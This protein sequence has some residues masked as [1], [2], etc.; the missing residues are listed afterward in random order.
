MGNRGSRTSD[1]LLYALE[2]LSH[3]DFKRFKDKLSHVDFNGRRNIPRGKLEKAD[4]IDTKNLLTKFYGT[5]AAVDVTIEVFTRV[6]LME[7]AARLQEERERALTC[8][9]AHGIT[10]AAADYRIRYMEHIVE[11]YRL[12]EDRNA[13]IG[14]TV[15]LQKRYTKLLIINKHRLVHELKHEV[16]S[17]GRKHITI[18][19][20]LANSMHYT[21]IEALFNSAK[22]GHRPQTV[23]LL[24]PAGIGKTM[25]ARKIMLDWASGGLYQGLFSY[26]FYI[27]CRE[28]NQVQSQKSVTD[29]ISATC[30]NWTV[31]K[32][33]LLAEPNTLLFIVDGFDELKFSLDLQENQF[34]SDPAK[35]DNVEVTLSNLFRRNIL[36]RCS[37]LITTRPTALARL[38]QY[39]LHPLCAEIMGFTEEDRWS[40]FKHFFE[41]NSYASRAFATVKDNDILYTMCFVPI[42]CWIVCTVIKQQIE[43]E[44]DI[45]SASKTT[46]SLYL[47]FLSTLLRDHSRV[48][49]PT[50]QISLKRL[51]SLALDGIMKQRIL[52]YEEDMMQYDLKVSDVQ[53]LF[54]NTTIFQQDIDCYTAY[55]FIHLSFQEFF[56]A[57]YYV[58]DVEMGSKDSPTGYQRDIKHLL[59][60]SSKS[61]GSHLMLTVRFLFGL[62]NKER[63]IHVEKTLGCK[64]S[65]K[66]RADLLAWIQ[67]PKQG[68]LAL[69][70]FLC[71]FET[72][73]EDVVKSSMKNIQSITFAN[74]Y[75][76]GVQYMD[77]KALAFCLNN[78]QGDKT[79]IISGLQVGEKEQEALRPALKKCSTIRLSKC[80]FSHGSLLAEDSSL[81]TD[82]FDQMHATRSKSSDE[83]TITLLCKG[84]RN[85]PCHLQKLTM[86]ECSLSDGCFEDLAHVLDAASSLKELNLSKNPN[87]VR[88]LKALIK[89]L[90]QAN[91]DLQTLNLEDC[92]PSA[93]CCQELSLLLAHSSLRELNL[94]HN[95]LGNSGLES[96]CRGLKH[97]NCRIQ[98]LWLKNCQLT[99]QTCTSLSSALIVNWTLVELDL[100]DNTLG[101]SGM[102]RLCDCLK[103]AECN[104][105][106]L[107]V[108]T[109][110]LTSACCE[111]LAC[112]LVSCCSLQVLDLSFNALGDAG[113]LLLCDGLKHP[114]SRLKKLKVASCGL[115]AACCAHLA[116]A[117]KTNMSLVKLGLRANEL[118]DDG[119]KIF[120]Q[121]LKDGGIRLENLDLRE[122]E[123]TDVA[124]ADL[125]M[126]LIKN[127][128]LL[129]L[130]L[131]E[132]ELYDEGLILLCGALK[133]PDCKL[134]KLELQ[135]L[136]MSMDILQE[137]KRERPDLE[138]VTHCP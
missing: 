82:G 56:A 133:H 74:Y 35:K 39:V 36:P 1:I 120:C 62:I 86:E 132:L 84:L 81:P 75:P 100:S 93:D 104:L 37:L 79:L 25:T 94:C 73:D 48:S 123:M 116:S 85:Q 77:Y 3:D 135:V 105:Q 134:R 78:C 51:C 8:H 60:T 101:D 32:S 12:M 22:D 92:A 121:E 109:C 44:R 95:R 11:R 7:A 57:L 76:R 29:L 67:E 15:H 58:L 127:P 14:E 87:G 46:T 13:R 112:A 19:D 6:M 9:K 97:P 110:G 5:N 42:V 55:S 31:P 43:R 122:S 71:L 66:A 68:T 2:D 126:F 49:M 131:N 117:L 96:I 115:T 89:T 47:F 90:A 10:E 70:A 54:L 17:S 69:D 99:A 114:S 108:Q 106:T 136:F 124:C 103:P 130:N 113:M 28:I 40:Y 26:I 128:S 63:M 23:V 83:S 72:Q 18:M 65:H 80:R 20:N 61:S 24:G 138:L 34:C 52:F 41:D 21:S 38:G 16:M 33:V 98:T 53:S 30:P 102:A 91:H 45:V 64:V 129:K 88:G 119:V 4:H 50:R 118:G 107:R 137:L 125:A 27:S 59:E 111:G